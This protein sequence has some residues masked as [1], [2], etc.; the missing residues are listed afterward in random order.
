MQGAGDIILIFTPVLHDVDFPQAGQPISAKAL[1]LP[2]AAVL[3]NVFAQ[4][5]D[6]RPGANALR[7]L[8][9]YVDSSIGKGIFR[10]KPR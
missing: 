5:P 6:C 1:S 9:S 7:Q 2:I 10:I 3:G 8:G 4:C